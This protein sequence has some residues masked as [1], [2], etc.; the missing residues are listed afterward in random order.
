MGHSMPGTGSGCLNRVHADREGTSP[1]STST[2]TEQEGL[3]LWRTPGPPQLSTTTIGLRPN[4]DIQEPVHIS[5]LRVRAGQARVDAVRQGRDTGRDRYRGSTDAPY[6][7]AGGQC[8]DRLGAGALVRR[9]SDALHL[10]P[11]QRWPRRLDPDRV[12]PRVGRAVYVGRTQSPV[13]GHIRQS[14]VDD[15]APRASSGRRGRRLRRLMPP[16][17]SSRFAHLRWQHTWSSGLQKQRLA[18][19]VSPMFGKALMTPCGFAGD[20]DSL[21]VE[22]DETLDRLEELQRARRLASWRV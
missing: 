15:R 4:G 3:R 12:R 19:T 5:G 20:D 14:R 13:T 22:T 16:V 18:V 10:L 17:W 7:G 6:R 2:E 11:A 9:R 1:K 21:A 8:L